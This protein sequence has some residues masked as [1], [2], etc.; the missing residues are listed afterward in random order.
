MRIKPSWLALWLAVT[1]TNSVNLQ[2]VQ[3]LSSPC[4][5]NIRTVM[6]LSAVASRVMVEKCKVRLCDRNGKC[7]SNTQPKHTANVVNKI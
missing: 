5:V 6:A 2:C 4:L 1:G 3:S 7:P